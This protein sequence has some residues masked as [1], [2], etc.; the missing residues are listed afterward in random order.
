MKI[1]GGV[2]I[3]TVIDVVC[4]ACSSSTRSE[5]GGLQYA[6]L[7]AHWGYGTRH[8]GER[9]ELRICEDCFFKAIAYLK[10]ELRTENLFSD[11]V[12]DA[13]DDFG[14]VARDGFFGE[15]GNR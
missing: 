8:D 11:K 5:N 7:H 13:P 6:S 10:Q 4:D 15:E 9:Y 12:A 3:E 2:E 14:L 1:T